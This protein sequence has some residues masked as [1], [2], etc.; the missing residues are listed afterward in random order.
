MQVVHGSAMNIAIRIVVIDMT[1]RV[2]KVHMDRMT[3][4]N[5]NNKSYRVP[6]EKAKEFKIETYGT[7]TGIFGDLV[8]RLGQYEDLGS[9]EELKELAK[10]NNKKI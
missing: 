10:M 1:K 3:V 4:I 6:L 8:N 5:P 2:S 7:S 9:I